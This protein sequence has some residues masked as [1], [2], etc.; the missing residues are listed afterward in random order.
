IVDALVA[1]LRSRPD[2]VVSPMLPDDIQMLAHLFPVLRRVQP[3]AER[4]MRNLSALDS[5]QVR[6]RAFAA[7][8]QLLTTVSRETPL[9]LFI[10][11]LQWGDGQSATVL[12]ALFSR[13]DPPPIMFLGSY[14]S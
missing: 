7:L 12:Y 2:E 5:Q 10:D 3:I 14:R 4:S 11:N 8:G 9:V 6:D 1:F 13:P